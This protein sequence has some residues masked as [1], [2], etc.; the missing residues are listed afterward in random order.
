MNR[1]RFGCVVALAALLAGCAYFNTF[2]NAGVF[3][4]EGMRLK[5]Q[6]QVSAAVPKFDKAI[7]KSALVIN[8]WPKSRWVDDA[9]FLIGRS[10]Y[11][12]GDYARA[13]TYFERLKLAFAQSP[14]LPE[15]ELYRGLALLRSG[16]A[17]SARLV[18]E[19]VKRRYPK[20]GR[21]ADFYTALYN[22]EQG[23][24][25]EGVDSLVALVQRYP[26][27]PYMKEAVSK[28]A[29]GKMQLGAYGEAERWFR[30]YVELEPAPR[31]RAEAQMKIARCRLEQGKAEEAVQMVK[32]ALGKYADLD[33]ALNLLLGKAYL[34]LGKNDEAIGALVRVR[35][36]NA[37]G[38][39]AAF[40]IG[41]FYEE[42]K[43]FSRA[44]VYYDSARLRRADS[45][46]GV[47]AAKRLALLQA[48]EEDTTGTRDSAEMKFLLAE[49]H[50]LN[51]EEFDTALRLYQEVCDSFPQS[52]LAPKALFARAWILLYKKAD[53]IATRDELKRIVQKYPDTEYAQESKKWLDKLGR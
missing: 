35:G 28:I 19:N 16:E 38:A 50:N 48:L 10:Y 7:E 51:L 18:L 1:L 23:E 25:Q 52:P 53:T 22:I 12:K 11:E 45:E 15:A 33:E 24:I 30:R 13:A 14:Y 43:D 31:L 8:R 49:V 5:A 42:N 3:Y 29:E 36:N 9:L 26:R 4:R 6:G 21:V 2:Y 27:L 37:V 17:G 47:L 20:L 39:E 46:Q 44:K 32:E 40:L 34:K 41:R